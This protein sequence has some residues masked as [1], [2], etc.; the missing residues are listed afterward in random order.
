MIFSNIKYI[1][2]LIA[3]EANFSKENDT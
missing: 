2:N 3:V 1:P